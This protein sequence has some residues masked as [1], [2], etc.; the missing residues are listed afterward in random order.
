VLVSL[1]RSILFVG[2]AYV[3]IGTVLLL[4]VHRR[5]FIGMHWTLRV[6]M[7]FISIAL[8]PFFIHVERTTKRICK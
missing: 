1:L 2:A 7:K 6:P 8:W 3:F 4:A 5:A